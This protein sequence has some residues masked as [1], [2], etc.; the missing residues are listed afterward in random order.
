MDGNDR[1]CDHCRTGVALRRYCRVCSSRA[2]TLYKRQAR[3]E[4]KAAGERYWFDWWVKTYGDA[5]LLQ[6]REY[7]REY[8]RRYRRLQPVGRSA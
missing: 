6:R 8:M 3:R 5:A 2:S 7:Q 1:R 4:A